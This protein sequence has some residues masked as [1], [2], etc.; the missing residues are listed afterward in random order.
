MAVATLSDLGIMLA[1]FEVA[2]KTAAFCDRDV[3][4]LDDLGMA[5]RAP[6]LFS[7]LE[8]LQVNLVVEHDF[9]E[10]VQSLEESFV[11][12]PCTKARFIGYFS[13]RLGFQ[14]ELRPITADLE[15]PFDFSPQL[16]PQPRRIVADVAFDIFVGGSLPTLIKR[17]H[18]VAGGTKL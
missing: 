18:I 9:L 15:E 7:S 6:E 12:T 5:A 11:V 17:F 10:L 8:V 4:T 14:V 16:G 3:F 13:P 1:L 2:N